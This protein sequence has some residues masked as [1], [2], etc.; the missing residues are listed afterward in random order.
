[1]TAPK[2][3]TAEAGG[4]A[5]APRTK[6]EADRLRRCAVTGETR[7]PDTL[8]RFALD[9][10]GRVFPDPAAAA[11]G[12][13]VW[14]TPTR[15]TVTLA[16]KRNVFA[17][18]VKGPAKPEADLPEKTEAALVHRCLDR[19]SMARKAGALVL[20]FDQVDSYLRK[21]RPAW[22]IE[23]SD[24]ADDGRLKLG[25]VAFAVWTDE[26][27]GEPPVCGAFSSAE[28]GVALQRDRVIHAALS[29]GRLAE[30]WS[31]D[32]ARLAGF[33]PLRPTGWAPDPWRSGA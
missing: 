18:S 15:E 24:G 9:A 28:L 30:L 16:V 33:R 23:A 4:G 10:D 2:T 7:E 19:L 5:N 26:P 1:M 8:L 13:G 12:R 22:R 31:A 3:R 32:L 14:L 29:S 11:P 21:D 20:G 17:K 27:E 6:R 25:R